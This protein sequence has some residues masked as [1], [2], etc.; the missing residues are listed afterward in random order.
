MLTDVRRRLLGL[1]LVA[2]LVLVA[3]LAGDI[4]G[5]IS[6]DA[7]GAQAE[8][9]RGGPGDPAT[10]LWVAAALAASRAPAGFVQRAGPHLVADGRPW[11]PVGFD[12]YTLTSFAGDQVTCG[13]AHRSA[14]IDQ[15]LAG[16]QRNGVTAVRTW[17]FQSYVAGRDGWSPFDAVLRS[18]ARH[19]IRVIATLSNQWGD[20]ENADGSPS[21]Y[22]TLGWYRDGYAVN[23]DYGLPQ[24]YLDY[25]RSVAARYRDNS[26]IAFW[27]LMNEAEAAGGR[28]QPCDEPAASRALRSFADTVTAAIQAVDP[29]HLVSLGT[30][31]SGQC[32]TSGSDY[33]YVHAGRVDLCEYHDYAPGAVNGDQWNGMKVDMQTCLAMGKPIFAGEV[34]IDA[35][36]G[37]R[38]RATGTVTAGTLAQRTAFFTEKMTAQFDAGVSGFLIWSAGWGRSNQYDVGPG[39]PSYRAVLEVAQNV[40][41]ARALYLRLAGTAPH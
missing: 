27:Q 30:I 4:G 12:D 23:H 25:V 11:L 3:P 6:S 7:S 36:V 9:H 10:Q 32:G 33:R 41:T 39:D 40:A 26:T 35:S 13:T 8:P 28:R 18:A 19:R 22:K 5:G 38:W 34:G 24:T 15:E 2:V 20:C 29:H 31:G 17:F 21:T 37:A 1:G 16:F 14:D